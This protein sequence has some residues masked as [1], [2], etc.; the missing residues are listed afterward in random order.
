MK[1]AS[2]CAHEPCSCRAERASR[3][4]SAE[5]EGSAPQAAHACECGHPG[6]HA[7]DEKSERSLDGNQGEGHREAADDLDE[8]RRPGR[9]QER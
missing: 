8:L 3:F 5:C 6:C 9:K 2:D 1:S 4:C 7:K